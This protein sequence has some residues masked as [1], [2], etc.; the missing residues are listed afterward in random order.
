MLRKSSGLIVIVF[1]GALLG[2]EAL[3]A[4]TETA[5]GWVKAL[6]TITAVHK[7]ITGIVTKATT[8]D[9]AGGAVPAVTTIVGVL[10]LLW[11]GAR[12]LAGS[13]PAEAHTQLI[14]THADTV[15]ALSKSTP[16]SVTAT[17]PIQPKEQG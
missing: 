5:P 16:V 2:C 10:G 1:L 9:P 4:P 17:M 12:K 3:R 6:D 13:V 14:A 15:D 11:Y 7:D 8:P